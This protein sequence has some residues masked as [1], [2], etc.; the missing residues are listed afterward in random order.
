M[1]TYRQTLLHDLTALVAFL[2]GEARVH[3]DDL[4]SSTLSL[5]FKNVEECAPTSVHDALCQGMILDHVEHLKLLNSNHLVLFGIA[6]SR[7]IVKIAPL[8]FDLEMRLRSASSSL[9]AAVTA[10]L[11]TAQLALFAPQGLLRGAIEARVR[12]GVALTIGQ[13]GLSQPFRPP[14]GGNS[15]TCLKAVAL[16]PHLGRKM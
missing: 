14:A 16:L 6:F 8:P 4:M 10:L 2:R 12:G 11:A 15:P 9:T 3:S 5:H 13:K 7:L 1:S